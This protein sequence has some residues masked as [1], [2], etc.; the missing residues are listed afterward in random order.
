MKRS[1]TKRQ[2]L[3]SAYY[4]G[5]VSPRHLSA[6]L[7]FLVGIGTFD[8][9]AFLWVAVSPAAYGVLGIAASIGCFIFGLACWEEPPPDD[10]PA[11]EG[12]EAGHWTAS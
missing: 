7:L 4:G 9:A 2:G 11:H 1:T 3:L 12:E 10:E 5:L 8:I 6:A